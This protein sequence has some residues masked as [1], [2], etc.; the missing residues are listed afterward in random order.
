LGSG[1][2]DFEEIMEHPFFSGLD[3]E[4]L[5]EK[6]I[7]P[8]YHPSSSRNK[9]P[10]TELRMSLAEEVYSQMKA[11]GDKDSNEFTNFSFDASY[12]K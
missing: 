4:L 6:K 8:L 2:K 1:E 7:T 10:D 5:C 12:L 3:W 9:T 11:S